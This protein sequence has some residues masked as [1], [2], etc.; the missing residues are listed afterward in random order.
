MYVRILQ[1]TLSLVVSC[2]CF[3]E[4][5]E[6]MYQKVE[7]ACRAIVLLSQLF[8]L[9]RSCYRRRR[10]FVNS[11]VSKGNG[12]AQSRVISFRYSTGAHSKVESGPLTK[13]K[14]HDTCSRVAPSQDTVTNLSIPFSSS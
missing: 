5:G 8:V 1:E 12:S 14:V 2:R 6:E 9:R 10:G 3:S 7:R 13:K 11:P 4:K